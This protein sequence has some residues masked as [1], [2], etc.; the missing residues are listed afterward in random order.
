MAI[1]TVV[2]A[3][4]PLAANSSWRSTSARVVGVV[5]CGWQD[6]KC[7]NPIRLWGG[8]PRLSRSRRPDPS[9]SRQFWQLL[10]EP[11]S[12]LSN[13]L[14]GTAQAKVGQP[15]QNLGYFSGAGGLGMTYAHA[16]SKQEANRCPRN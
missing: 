12:Q 10:H 1:G 13:R 15:D 5:S 9:P 16:L 2:G 14:D 11:L 8:F 3:T 6:G 7:R 4:Q